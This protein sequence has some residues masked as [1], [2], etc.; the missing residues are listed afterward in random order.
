VIVSSL[1]YLLLVWL[2][3]GM[4]RTG[5]FFIFTTG[6]V[7]LLACLVALGRGR[8][9]P[10]F[11]L[12]L[13]TMLVGVMVGLL[14]LGLR[15]FP[16]VLSGAVANHAYGGYHAL[17]GGIYELDDHLGYALRP[18]LTRDLYWNGHW[19]RHAT[20]Q[21]GYRGP[22]REQAEALFIGDSMIYGHGLANGDTVPSRFEQQAGMT[23]VNLGQ[24]GTCLVQMWVR[25]AEHGEKLRPRYVFVCS[26]FN[27]ID[28][29]CDWYEP[30]ELQR[31][32]AST[33][34]DPELPLARPCFRRRPPWRADV[35]WNEHLAVALRSEG[36][37]SGL[38]HRLRQPTPVAVNAPNSSEHRFVPAAEL[39]TKPFAP[40]S[41]EATEA[42]RL[43]WQAH[44]QALAKIAH[45]CREHNATPVFFDLGYP[46]EFS[47]A[48]EEQS[49]R[50]AVTYSPAGRVA[51]AQALAGEDIYLARDGHWSARGSAVVAREL[52]RCL[53]Q[54]Q[55]TP[56]Y[57]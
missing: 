13:G 34:S 51:L 28:E 32:V 4:S 11:A 24:Q 1:V 18:N 12:Y 9:G 7:C 14:E 55:G 52:C 38:V 22:L 26:H 15:L 48:I 36:A 54:T 39:V 21:A 16:G 47:A 27:D 33:V 30:V 8:R 56:P 40:W 3:S 53:S 10:L 2:L 5:G 23:S 25:L 20:N 43:G 45:W 44:C 29:G 49:H 41:T 50:L 57:P 37:L 42:Q 46:R 31:F 19:W 6:L 17:P 35:F